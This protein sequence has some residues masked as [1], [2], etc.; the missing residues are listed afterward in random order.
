MMGLPL[1]ARICGPSILLKFPERKSAVGTD[2]RTPRLTR[3]NVPSQSAKKNSLFRLIGPPM[4][5]PSMLR[6]PLGLSV[7]PARFS[8][9]VNARHALL[10]CIANTLPR[11]LFVP[12]LV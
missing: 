11:K 6:V 7:T 3:S 12:D 5:P 10:S 2:D 9:Q 1:A 8:S 4:L